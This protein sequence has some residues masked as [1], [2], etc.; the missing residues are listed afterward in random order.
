MLKDDN[1][2]PPDQLSDRNLQS[3]FLQVKSSGNHEVGF[4]D[5]MFKHEVNNNNKLETLNYEKDDAKVER[6]NTN[7]INVNRAS[8]QPR[9]LEA[10]SDIELSSDEDKIDADN[11]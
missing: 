9:E 6:S 10:G 4:I 1:S 2:G 8:P 5:S 3:E 7:F 11:Q